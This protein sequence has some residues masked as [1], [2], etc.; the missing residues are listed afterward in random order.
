[1]NFQK[2]IIFNYNQTTPRGR[3]WDQKSSQGREK[4][5]LNCIFVVIVIM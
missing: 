1:M 2:K 4:V 5:R 3:K